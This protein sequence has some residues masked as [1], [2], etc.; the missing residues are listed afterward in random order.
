METL[1]LRDTPS[2][3]L[4]LSKRLSESNTGEDGVRHELG[5]V[6]SDS[7]LCLTPPYVTNFPLM[8][9]TSS[10]PQSTLRTTLFSNKSW[11]YAK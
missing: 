6:L 4:M 10:S 9:Q 1:P 5:H 7:A 3:Q 11:A 2:S 8:V